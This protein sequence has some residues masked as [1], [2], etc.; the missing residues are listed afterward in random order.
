MKIKFILTRILAAG[1]A[2]V[3]LFTPFWGL[4]PELL[5][6]SVLRVLDGDTVEFRPQG[7][8]KAVKLRLLFIDAPE[9]E[10][11]SREGKAIGVFS[12]RHLHQ[13]IDG[14]SLQAELAGL[15]RYGR[16]LGRLYRL[17]QRLGLQDV[18]ELQVSAGQALL[19]PFQSSV[20]ASYQHALAWAKRQ[21]HGLFNTRGFMSPYR[22]RRLKKGKTLFAL[23]KESVNR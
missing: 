1:A 18:G 6:G 17:D 20:P 10:Q 2:V 21:H 22:F 15:D 19:Y 7:Q 13:S 5:K 11:T 4:R 16:S 8:V 12:Q 23:G 9:L 14:Y 3:F